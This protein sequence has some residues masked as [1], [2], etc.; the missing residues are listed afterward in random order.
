V[1][2]FPFLCSHADEKP[3]IRNWMKPFLYILFSPPF[4]CGVRSSR[5][6]LPPLAGLNGTQSQTEGRPRQ[7][8]SKADRGKK[9]VGSAN[10]W[11]EMSHVEIHAIFLVLIFSWSVN[12][13]QRAGQ[14]LLRRF[15]QTKKLP[16][17]QPVSTKMSTRTQKMI[18]NPW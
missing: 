6:S 16:P 2:T 7:L 15:L 9:P 10:P 13:C 14:K 12:F 8:E 4:S 17:R 5:G 3:K 11:Q 1:V 18:V